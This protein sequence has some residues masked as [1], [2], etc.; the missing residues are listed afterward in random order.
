MLLLYW[1]ECAERDLSMQMEDVLG[2]VL[3]EGRVMV[4]YRA[5]GPR[6]NL[7]AALAVGLQDAE[8]CSRRP[9][10][11]FKLLHVQD[12]VASPASCRDLEA[13]R[14]RYGPTRMPAAYFAQINFRVSGGCGPVRR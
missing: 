14:S 8:R 3:G 2:P 5:T 6:S 11:S 7:H 10:I 1:T 9:K 4:D 13:L 12:V